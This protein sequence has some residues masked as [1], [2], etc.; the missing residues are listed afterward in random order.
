MRL[1]SDSNSGFDPRSII[2]QG[3]TNL[4][5]LFPAE[6][7]FCGELINRH[8]NEKDHWIMHAARCGGVQRC[9]PDRSAADAARI[10]LGAAYGQPVAVQ[11]L[12][13][14][15]GQIERQSENQ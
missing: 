12:H 7:Y 1:R 8:G 14:N 10:R 9:P 2:E 6:A 3:E 15:G 11:R 5:R 4:F 13:E